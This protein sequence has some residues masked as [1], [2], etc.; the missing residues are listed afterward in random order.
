[1]FPEELKAVREAID[2]YWKRNNSNRATVIPDVSLRTLAKRR[3]GNSKKWAAF[4]SYFEEFLQLPTKLDA[5]TERAAGH[6]FSGIAVSLL[7]ND[8]LGSVS[9]G[10]IPDLQQAIKRLRKLS[11]VFEST[12]GKTC[13]Y[14]EADT[15]YWSDIFSGRVPTGFPQLDDALGGGLGRGELGVVIGA[16]GGGKTTFLIN[17]GAV[18]MLGGLSVLHVSME[19]SQWQVLLRYDMRLTGE[20]R[21]SLQKNGKYIV[22]A[23]KLVSRSGGSLALLDMSHAVM[24]PAM[25]ESTLEGMDKVDLVLVD[26]A[27]LMKADRYLQGFGSNGDIGRRFELGEIYRELRRIAAALDLPVWTASQATREAGKK[28][29][30]TASDVGEDISKMHTADVGLCLLQPMEGEMMLLLDKTRMGKSGI[31]VPVLADFS[32]ATILE[33]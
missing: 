9:G 7:A 15:D 27:D 17:L 14:S 3:L 30:F 26:Y 5:A 16:W 24:T 11:S 23:R 2:D 8:L 1:V 22:G 28:G 4:A 6:S 18:A 10:Q 21:E 29:V 32:T 12:Q 19:L 33:G 13:V 25:L 31:K 20:T